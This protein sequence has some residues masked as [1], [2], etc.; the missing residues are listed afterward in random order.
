MNGH[1]FQVH[2]ESTDPQQFGKTVEALGEYAAKHLGKHS[3]D[4]G[5]FFMDLEVP[6]AN[7]PS[8]FSII[9]TC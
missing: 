9:P 8:Q 3:G 4:L 7:P 1:V 5:S 2:G 6:I